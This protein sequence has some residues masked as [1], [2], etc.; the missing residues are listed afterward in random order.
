MQRVGVATMAQQ[1][2]ATSVFMMLV[3]RVPR[4]SIRDLKHTEASF[5]PNS[6]NLLLAIPDHH[7][8]RGG[9]SPSGSTIRR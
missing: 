5:S 7:F 6:I 3:D 2:G 9:R 4:P 1:K 8:F